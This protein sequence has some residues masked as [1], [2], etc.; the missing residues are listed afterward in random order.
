MT[1]KSEALAKAE[2]Y[3]RTGSPSVMILG[4][5]AQPPNT[6]MTII[7]AD[8]GKG[9]WMVLT[10]EDNVMVARYDGA[11]R[12]IPVVITPTPPTP[13]LPT[14]PAP[15]VSEPSSGTPQPQVGQVK[16]PIGPQN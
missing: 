6:N 14:P 5:G 15:W 9:K 4:E 7:N 16:K 12:A 13:V 1:S 10:L 3:L 8:I 2:A 11:D